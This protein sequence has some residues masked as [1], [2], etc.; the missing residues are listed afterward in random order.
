MRKIVKVATVFAVAFVA[1]IMTADAQR[2]APAAVVQPT[3]VYVSVRQAPTDSIRPLL[4]HMKRGATFGAVT[5]VVLSGLVIFALSQDSQRCCDGPT[6][7]PTL[8]GA[9]RIVS[10]GAAGGSAVGAFFGF[11]YHFQLLEKRRSA[12]AHP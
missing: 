3:L 5:G 12:T 7:S 4:F 6:R 10:I 8:G 1:S 11:T 2:V 9:L